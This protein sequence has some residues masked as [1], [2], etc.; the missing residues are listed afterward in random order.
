MQINPSEITPEN[1]Y[2]NRK[3]LMKASAAFL[4]AGL[5]GDLFAGNLYPKENLKQTPHEAVTSYNNFYEFSTDKEE[6]KALAKNFKFYP[7]NIT[8]SGHVKKPGTYAIET[9]MKRFPTEDRIYRFRC[10][11]GWSMVIPWL[12]FPLHKL[13]AYVQPTN[14]AKFVKFTTLHDPKQMPGQK[15]S[16]FQWPYTE[17][18]RLDEAMHDLTLLATGLYGKNL[19]PQNGAP[20]R[21]VVPWKYGFKSIKSIVKIEL[22]ETMPTTFWMAAG[23]AEYGFYSNVNPEVSHPRWTQASERKIGESGRIKTLPFNGYEKQV[24]HLYKGM[25]LRKYF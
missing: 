4:T 9:I 11:E 12:G 22:V 1:L 6:V 16:W 19:L 25:D 20:L 23:P 13:L 21:L 3:Q 14:K 17:G 10:V 5:V 15:G 18:L 7:W 24:A 2:L 8:V